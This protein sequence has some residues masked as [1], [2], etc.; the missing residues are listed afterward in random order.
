MF[1]SWSTCCH[2]TVMIYAYVFMSNE[3]GHLGHS[4]LFIYLSMDILFIC[5]FLFIFQ[6]DCVACQKF[7][8]RFLAQ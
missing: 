5:L 2:T 7:S 1:V 4:I 6:G 3:R 8:R